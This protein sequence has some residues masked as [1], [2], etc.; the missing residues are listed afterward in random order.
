MPNPDD[1]ETEVFGVDGSTDEDLYEKVKARSRS[2]YAELLAATVSIEE[3][4]RLL[5]SSTL[6]VEHR[7]R[8]QTIWAIDDNGTWRI[9]AIQFHRGKQVS[10]LDRVL[11]MILG[12]SP[13]AVL[14]LL[15]TEQADYGGKDTLD[16]LIGGGSLE[17][18]LRMAERYQWGS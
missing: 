15:T 6:G 1:R 14:G 4:S 16:W 10:G 2:A 11:P 7:I 8:D 3:C 9:P 17:P 12:G 13:L 5:G 18:V